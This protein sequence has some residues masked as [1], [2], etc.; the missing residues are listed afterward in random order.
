M[1]EYVA[2]CVNQCRCDVP[3]VIAAGSIEVLSY[4]APSGVWSAVSDKGSVSS[5]S[6]AIAGSVSLSWP[7]TFYRLGGWAVRLPCI[8]YKYYISHYKLQLDPSRAI[9]GRTCLLIMRFLC[10]VCHSLRGDIFRFYT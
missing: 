7:S 10:G 8:R 2:D 1:E 6:V 4:R 9:T 5:L 3:R